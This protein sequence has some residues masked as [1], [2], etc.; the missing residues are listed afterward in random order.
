MNLFLNSLILQEKNPNQFV[1]ISAK[2]NN[3]KKKDPKKTQLLKTIYSVKEDALKDISCVRNE[4]RRE[5]LGRLVS[6]SKICYTYDKLILRQQ[7]R[8]MGQYRLPQ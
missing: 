6:K 7:L 4:S 5:M 1:W 3:F 8:P 2:M